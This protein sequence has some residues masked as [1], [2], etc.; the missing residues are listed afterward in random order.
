MW[1][2]YVYMACG[3]LSCNIRSI[4]LFVSLYLIV[5]RKFSAPYLMVPSPTFYDL[6]YSHNTSLTDRWTDDNRA[7][8]STII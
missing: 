7:N 6:L 3:C 4:D 5:Y 8:S 1:L 2:S